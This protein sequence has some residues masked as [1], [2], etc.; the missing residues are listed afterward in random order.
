MHRYPCSKTRADLVAAA[1]GCAI[2]LSQMYSPRETTLIG[3]LSFPSDLVGLSLSFLDG[4]SLTSYEAAS[5]GTRQSLQ[6]RPDM[7]KKL[8]VSRFRSWQLQHC[9]AMM[10]RDR[11]SLQE[12]IPAVV[13]GLHIFVRIFWGTE[14]SLPFSN[15]T[16]QQVMSVLNK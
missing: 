7:F 11:S 1:R 13:A 2:R 9:Q 15:L 14:R 5:K 3:R 8:L 6:H 4:R 12:D 10:H 16:A